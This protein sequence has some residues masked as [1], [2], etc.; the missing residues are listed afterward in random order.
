M[1]DS[2]PLDR[3]QF[4]KGLLGGTA[5]LQI[6]FMPPLLQTTPFAENGA[7]FNVRDYGA[8][9]DGA[10][11]DTSA[12]LSTV[13]AV[14][15]AGGGSI[16]VPAGVYVVTQEIQL[17]S[18]TQFYGDGIG[19]TIITLPNGLNH[20]VIGIVRTLDYE[21]TPIVSNVLVR[22]LTIDGNR[23]NQTDGLQFGFYCGSKT[24]RRHFQITALR[25]EVRNCKGYGFDPHE[26]T[27]RM[28]IIECI[29]HDN[30]RDGFTLDGIVDGVVRGCIAYN[31]DRH[32]FNVITN[33]NTVVI[34][35][36]IA[37][38]NG[39]NGFTIQNGAN[40]IQITTCLSYSNEND[41][42][43]CIGVN[44]NQ[45][46]N[47]QI[48]LNRGNGIR[49]RGCARTT[50]TGNRLRDN[51]Q[52][53]HDQFNEIILDDDDTL[54][55]VDTA[56]IANHITCTGEVRARYGI[57]E[58]P[59]EDDHVQTRNAFIANKVSGGATSDYGISGEDSFRDLGS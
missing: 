25:I 10:T 36:C 44:D 46:T 33:T 40:G 38:N 5:A 51:S 43:Y 15:A 30:E 55:T 39:V 29:S 49:I 9:G 20:D 58:T 56:V 35:H 16:Y 34:S 50:I 6:G 18:N 4:L 13:D 59:G 42:I 19:A 41:G 31:N 17:I 32:G 48:A 24:P 12:I 2:K 3:R 54:G 52:G 22:D 21:T 27:E 47:N 1:T 23:Q 8:K 53:E 7:V 45:I 28:Y 37:H 11:D 14:N 57:R 26:W